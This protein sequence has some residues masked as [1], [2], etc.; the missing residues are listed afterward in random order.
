MENYQ[1][2]D[3]RDF[4]RNEMNST[5]EERD[6]VNEEQDSENKEK[7]SLKKKKKSPKEKRG[8]ADWAISPDIDEEFSGLE[9]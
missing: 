5:K 4:V 3:Q 1:E 6:T 7:S 2:E 8:F 9:D